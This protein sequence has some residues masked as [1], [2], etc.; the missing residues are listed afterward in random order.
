M[1]EG[2]LRGSTRRILTVF[3]QREPE[4]DQDTDLQ[5]RESTHVRWGE[6]DINPGL[7]VAVDS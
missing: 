7:P 4:Y 6:Q 1:V 2:Q 5:Q 3:T